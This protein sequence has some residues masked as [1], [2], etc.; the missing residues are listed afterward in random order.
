MTSLATVQDD[1]RESLIARHCRL[2]RNKTARS[3]THLPD[4]FDLAKRPYELKSATTNSVTT[5]RDVGLHTL[6]DWKQR[7]WIIAFGTN[8]ASGF[9]IRE[10]FIAHPSDLSLFFN[11]LEERLLNRSRLCDE[12]LERARVGGASA[13]TLAAVKMLMARGMTENNPH[14]SR[15]I[16]FDNA[17]SLSATDSGTASAAIQEFVILHPLL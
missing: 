4:A 11:R 5:A 13:E 3:N 16:I 2:I 10:L 17:T 7:Y 9:R 12:V 14:I 6:Q 8:L 15:K 1:S